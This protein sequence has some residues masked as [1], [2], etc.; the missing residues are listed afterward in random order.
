MVFL[1]GRQKAWSEITIIACIHPVSGVGLDLSGIIVDRIRDA[2]LV[3]YLRSGTLST[4]TQ[5][6]LSGW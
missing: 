3:T 2:D 4:T 6:P 5:I 1:D